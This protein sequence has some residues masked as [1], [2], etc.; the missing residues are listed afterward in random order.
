MASNCILCGTAISQGILCPN[1]DRPRRAKPAAAIALDPVSPA[2]A[3]IGNVVTAAGAPAVIL[4][5]DRSVHLVTEAFKSLLGDI[6][7]VRQIEEA[8][9]IPI[10]DL[11][12]LSSNTISIR[13]RKMLLSV[14]PFAGGAAI[15]LRPL[16]EIDEPPQI[17]DIPRIADVIRSV[18]NRSIAFAE[19]KSIQ[20]DVSVPDFE[21]R[22]RH[23]DKLADAL[24]TL[25][26]NALHY[27]A[28]GGQIVVGV[29]PMEHKGKP[30]L[31]FFVMDNGPIVPEHMKH[32]IFESGFI[33]NANSHE[34]TG[35]GLFKVREFAASQGGSVWVD[36][37]SGRACTFFL[38]LN[39]DPAR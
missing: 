30:I 34:R 15:I 14:V 18:V 9:G 25:V 5:S 17:S 13:S 2:I 31:L 24:G 16:G 26:D 33:W 29:R 12:K 11:T 38:R 27:V 19:L 37:K 7:Q 23:H 35:R 4:D 36:S 22:F 6:T 3:T 32:L 28:A 20:V 39:P 21:E 1:C 10:H 8:L